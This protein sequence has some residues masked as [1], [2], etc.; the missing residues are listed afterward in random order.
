MLL[1][2]CAGILFLSGAL[3]LYTALVVPVQILV[4]D[5]G[6]PCHMFPTLYFDVSVDTFFMVNRGGEELNHLHDTVI[7]CKW[8][9]QISE[10]NH[11]AKACCCHV[12]CKNAVL[13]S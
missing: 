5:Y 11:V 10:Q 13:C 8:T 1:A 9:Y 12:M 3:L 7:V 4:W 6:D 2:F